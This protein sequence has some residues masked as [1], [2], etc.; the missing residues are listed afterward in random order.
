MATGTG[1]PYSIDGSMRAMEG[2]TTTN[3]VYVEE[4]I[5]SP[6]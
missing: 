4:S 6:M 3:A 5:L 2:D 1:I